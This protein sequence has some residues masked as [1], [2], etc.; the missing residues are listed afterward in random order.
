[1]NKDSF[2]VNMRITEAVLRRF[3]R[4]VILEVEDKESI[5][6]LGEKLKL[7]YGD[8][9]ELK[10]N[11]AANKIISSSNAEFDMQAYEGTG[12]RVNKVYIRDG[13]ESKDPFIY[14]NLLDVNSG[15]IIKDVRCYSEVLSVVPDGRMGQCEDINEG[16][17]VKLKKITFSDYKLYRGKVDL[18]ALIGSIFIVK[19]VVETLDFHKQKYTDTRY[20]IISP[21]GV[22]KDKNNKSYVIPLVDEFVEKLK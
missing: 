5:D 19:S 14:C 3:I 17:R 20:A 11:K 10:M 6:T 15:E 2:G 8:S 12:Y 18:Q 7:N 9:V 13:D 21:E 4:R 16:D 22:D 1:M